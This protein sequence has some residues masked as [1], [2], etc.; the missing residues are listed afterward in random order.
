M[1]NQK[2]EVSA[3]YVVHQGEL[4]LT[5]HNGSWLDKGKS[6]ESEKSKVINSGSCFGEWVLLGESS[7]QVTV[8]ALSDV[9]CWVITKS[10]FEAVVGNLQDIIQEDL[11]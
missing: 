4:K 2:D 5:Y 1:I 9:E 7:C 8:Q 10:R 6:V 3:L 11:K